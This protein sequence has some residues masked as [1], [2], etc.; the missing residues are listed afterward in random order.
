M[1][2]WQRLH[3]RRVPAVP[4]CHVGTAR[5]CHRSRG[6]LEVPGG[7]ASCLTFGLSFF[8]GR[9]EVDRAEVTPACFREMLTYPAPPPPPRPLPLSFPSLLR[10]VSLP[11]HS[12]SFA[13]PSCL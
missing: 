12:S 6:Q 2:E 8:Y 11:L 1:I 13:C 3:S 4:F 5:V 9:V 7:V 10:R